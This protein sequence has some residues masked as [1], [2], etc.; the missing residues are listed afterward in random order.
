MKRASRGAIAVVDQRVGAVGGDDRRVARDAGRLRGR[1]R[2]RGSASA[3]ERREQAFWRRVMPMSSAGDDSTSAS[4]SRCQAGRGDSSA[5]GDE[6]RGDHAAQAVAEQD[7]RAGAPRRGPRRAPPPGRRAGRRRRRAGRARP[8]SRRGRAGRS[9]RRS[10]RLAFRPRRD[11]RVAADVLAE[12]VD[13]DNRPPGVG[14][15]PVAARA[16]PARRGFES[17][18]P[19][20][21]SHA[22]T[23]TS[24]N[25]SH[26]RTRTASP[27]CS[28]T[29]PSA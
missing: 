14:G 18:V 22:M 4:T 9:R 11:V 23:D 25:S 10:S 16:A 26:F 8:G 28:S 2:R 6:A 17:S 19:S 5:A 3:A 21:T 15:R 13:D 12:A 7:E 24:T 29:G 1:C 27:T 20:L